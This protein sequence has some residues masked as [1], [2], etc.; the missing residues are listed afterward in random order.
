MASP[1]EKLKNEANGCR[2]SKLL[3]N[4]GTQ[5]LKTKLQFILNSCS[6]NLPAKLKDP[7]TKSKLKSLKFTNK[8]QWNLLYGTGSPDIE[9]F[10]ISLL[11]VL[12][13]NICGLT[14]PASGWNNLPSPS[15]NSVSANIAR[16]K[17]YRNEV[18]GHISTTG[19]DDSKFEDF[20]K[21]ISKALV[22]LGI[23]Q[24]EIDELREAPLSPEEVNY[25]DMLEKW[26]EREQ[27]L[28]DVAEK[29]KEDVGDIKKD[30]VENKK[31]VLQIEKKVE[32]IE[33]KMA[34]KADVAEVKEIVQ[35]K[36]YSNVKKLGKCNFKGLIA[37]L[38]KKHL[39]GTREWLFEKVDTWFND[40][41]TK[42]SNV[43]ILIAGPGVGKSVFAAEVC[44][45]YSEKKKL[46]ACHFCK[47]NRS[48]Y[49]NPRMLIESLA[50][51]MCDT[52]LGFKSKLN[53]ELQRKHSKESIA[54]AFRV[55]LN[56]PLHS[57]EDHEPMLLVIDALDESQ[58]DEK[59]ELLELIE[60]E[61]NKLPQWIKVFITSRPELLV[62]K[63]FKKMDPVEIKHDP[64][65]KNNE[66][67]LHKYL[68]HELNDH[69]E[70]ND[71]VDIIFRLLVRKCKGSFLYA[72]HAQL[73]L[74]EE[75]VELTIENIKRLV[76][77]GLSDFYT[78]QFKALLIEIRKETLNP[79]L[80]E[81]NFTKFL[82]VLV[83][84]RNS[85]P[86]KLLTSCIGFSDDVSFEVPSKISGIISQVLPV[87]DGCLTVYHKSLIDW[88]KSDGYEKH[89]FTVDG[90][91]VVNGHKLLR[92]ACE[93]EFRYIKSLTHFQDLKITAMCTYA[94]QNGIHHMLECGEDVDF[95]LVVDI[96]IIYASSKIFFLVWDLRSWLNCVLQQRRMSLRKDVIDEIHFIL[97]TISHISTHLLS[98]EF[99]P[100]YLQ[101][102]LNRIH[103][104]D[105]QRFLARS[106][107]HQGN[108][109]WF[110]DLDSTYLTNHYHST[111]SLRYKITSLCLSSNE[112]LLAVGYENG[113]LSILELPEFKERWCLRPG[114]DDSKST[115][116]ESICCCSFSPAG[117]R[118][119][120]SDFST[121]LK[122]WDVNN[123]RLLS[124]LQAD[125]IVDSC[126]F[127]DSGLFIAAELLEYTFCPFIFTAWN[128]FTLQ[129]VDRR[130]NIISP[131][132][133]CPDGRAKIAYTNYG[134]CIYE[135]LNVIDVFGNFSYVLPNAIDAYL[136]LLPL[137]SPAMKNHWR[138]CVFY[139][140]KLVLDTSKITELVETV[141]RNKHY[142][143]KFGDCPCIHREFG[144][145]API[146]MNVFY[147]VPYI[148]ELSVFKI[149]SYSEKHSLRCRDHQIK[150]CCFSPN[151]SFLATCSY[152]APVYID[153]WAIQHCTIVQTVQMQLDDALGCWWSNGL[154][155]I[156][157]GSDHLAK[158]LTSSDSFVESA[159]LEMINIGFKPKNILTFG[160]V[161]VCIDLENVVRVV[162]IINGE[163]QYNER[164]PIDNSKFKAA[165]SPD[166]SV[167]LTV[168][169]KKSIQISVWKWQNCESTV[170]KNVHINEI[171]APRQTD[172]T[173]FNVCLTSDGKKVVLVL[174]FFEI[175]DSHRATAFFRNFLIDVHSNGD[176]KPFSDRIVFNTE[177]L[178]AS[179][180]YCVGKNIIDGLVA[181][182]F[183]NGQECNM[184][185]HY[186]PWK[187][188]NVGDDNIPI[189]SMHPGT[190]TV[191]SIS[192]K[193]RKIRFLKVHF[194][195]INKH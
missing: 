53:E 179:E 185:I 141:D 98:K 52:I 6:S 120:T 1:P 73:A 64:R 11:T 59:S 70:T 159:G 3:I 110:E 108:S 138:E 54:D 30:V 122:L 144:T 18:Y 105:R 38:N 77:I 25:I 62:Q 32:K 8:E 172:I 134:R 118:L 156:W 125:G 96:R 60:E 149:D 130:R 103:S 150:C 24:T 56:D 178:L 74:K 35:D 145:V 23:Q 116:P 99:V 31:H 148:S 170:L 58:V 147:V 162:R 16:I 188:R 22:G 28:I 57:L 124:C 164:L 81:D 114:L 41:N 136:E 181:V 195:P 79:V 26:Y 43:M 50:S 5:A 37:N 169:R 67:D 133:Q 72:Y 135:L 166:N 186:V 45:R 95:S 4:K 187:S 86:I 19:V 119:V 106:M 191:V 46:A 177:I 100:Y 80:L 94:L 154:L 13:R 2:L 89:A 112:E 68:R 152:Y 88:L 69:E 143:T 10:D 157:D 36:T 137:P 129:R 127:V 71:H 194:P 51:T 104:S 171:L 9:E 155:W 140:T 97:D 75:N 101:C 102:V 193:R 93:E 173:R 163:I 167:I 174:V 84:C 189:A 48:D 85:L 180:S 113:E 14:P 184:K 175:S 126:S 20:W 76:P 168:C 109:A 161:L 146:T 21:E 29:T 107:L 91:C 153:I 42:T 190:D 183:E 176:P 44:R 63:K 90:H 139:H 131:P 87:Y 123:N 132:I 65:N 66:E 49:K 128:A 7:S 121:E 82:Q 165:V 12:L 92:N 33:E 182:H 34:T 39:P 117:N 78:K 27:E 151:G 115:K 192:N 158:I 160:D 15:D 17:Y 47:Y 111:V 142:K 61:F 40:K 55:L 83:A